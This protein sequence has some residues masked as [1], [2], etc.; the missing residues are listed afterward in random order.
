M[1]NEAFLLSICASHLVAA[2]AYGHE[3][4]FLF[5]ERTRQYIATMS[6][7]RPSSFIRAR[8]LLLAGGALLAFR[9]M[10]SLARVK[11]AFDARSPHDVLDGLLEGR[12]PE[13]SDRIRIVT[14]ELAENGEVVPITIESDLPGIE[15]LSFLAPENPRP[16]A[17]N[18]RLG[19]RTALPVT[20]RVKLAKTQDVNVL[21]HADGKDYIA[22]RQVRVVI[23]GC[24]GT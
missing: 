19:P 23:G 2:I 17:L 5:R 14:N 18:M 20:F 6:S 13:K 7:S 16:L 1:R 22:A 8:R 4:F 3:D 9:P 21:V 10:A 15:S 24:A 12:Q 11:P